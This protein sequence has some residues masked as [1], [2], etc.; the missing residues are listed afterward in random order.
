MAIIDGQYWPD[1]WSH[2]HR[3]AP[4]PAPVSSHAYTPPQSNWKPWYL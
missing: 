4:A 3:K 2:D 1:Q